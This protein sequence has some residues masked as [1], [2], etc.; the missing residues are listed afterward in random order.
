MQG[1]P[2]SIGI[3]LTNNN[4]CAQECENHCEHNGNYHE[5]AISVL[6]NAGIAAQKTEIIV[7]TKV[8]VH[9]NDCKYNGIYLG[10]CKKQ[11]KNKGDHCQNN[12]VGTGEYQTHKKNNCICSPE[13][14]KHY[15][16]NGNCL[17]VRVSVLRT[18]RII[19]KRRTH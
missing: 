13:C 5:K 15:K 12:G 16:P 18:A 19:I 4:I 6:K 9:K 2:K 11:C 10:E 14:Q 1:L 17:P 3:I 7:N 8:S